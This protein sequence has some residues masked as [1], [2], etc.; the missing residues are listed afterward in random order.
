MIDTRG[1][2]PMLILLGAIVLGALWIGFIRRLPSRLAWRVV[3]AST[4]F[5]IAYAVVAGNSPAWVGRLV[6]VLCVLTF[7]G[8]ILLAAVGKTRLFFATRRLRRVLW[9]IGETGKLDEQP[10]DGAAAPELESRA[11]VLEQLGFERMFAARGPRMVRI[12]LLRHE[13]RTIA[14]VATVLM[15]A[16]NPI[17]VIE[18][19]SILIGRRG[20]LST[21]TSRLKP[22]SWAGELCQV[23]PGSDPG[24]LV[25]HHEDALGFL[26]GRGITADRLTP[27]Q[28]LDADRW[29]RAAV[30]AG[31]ARASNQELAA[32]S[33]ARRTVPWD[34]VGPLG[35]DPAAEPRLSAFWKAIEAEEYDVGWGIEV[36]SD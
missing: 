33:H 28:V 11:M 15:P 6:A 27:E 29:A 23:F 14:E 32:R 35:A 22:G 18:L 34:F 1:S 17:P 7:L 9:R 24:P 12:V 8:V 31:S 13:D 10:F 3:A 25:R 5:L 20:L 30:A 21:S 4:V 26:S 19:T 2:V 16:L 36:D